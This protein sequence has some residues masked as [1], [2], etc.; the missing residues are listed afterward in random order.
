LGGL[1]Q[2]AELLNECERLSSKFRVTE[3]LS[4]ESFE[5]ST[6]SNDKTVLVSLCVTPESVVT[7]SKSLRHLQNI[8]SE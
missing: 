5:R 3:A 8:Q 2:E 7:L 1:D 6:G 4:F